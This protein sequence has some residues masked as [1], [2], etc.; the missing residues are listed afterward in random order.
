MPAQDFQE[1]ALRRHL[2]D[3]D[4]LQT[5]ARAHHTVIEAL[6]ARTTVLPLRLATV[7]LDDGRVEAMLSE[8]ADEFS[9]ALRRLAGHL[10]W[11]VKIYVEP[12]PDPQEPEGG[13]RTRMPPV[14]RSVRRW[15]RPVRLT[16]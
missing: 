5:V 10:E 15:R 4:W 7:Q 8:G 3:L 16:S 13:S 2:G 9:H 1:T 12:Q 14:R 6:A 11:G